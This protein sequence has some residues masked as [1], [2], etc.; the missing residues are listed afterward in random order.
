MGNQCSEPEGTSV[1]DTAVQPADKTV[2]PAQEGPG[3]EETGKCHESQESE[4]MSKP[5]GMELIFK[6]KEPTTMRF[7]DPEQP[8]LD[9][10]YEANSILRA[11]YG[12]FDNEWSKQKGKDVTKQIK[13]FLKK[14]KEIKLEMFGKPAENGS[15]VLLVELAVDTMKTFYFA[16]KPLGIV[17]NE[18]KTPIVVT[19]ITEKSNAENNGVKVGMTLVKVD[20]EDVV[21]MGYQEIVALLEKSMAA[22]ST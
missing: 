2:E 3:E 14:K 9:S 21:G 13:A 22:L 8:I 6:T 7:R 10:S 15:K 5:H 12:D 11:W 19:K 17:F 18:D 20:G 16:S 1:E 4:Y